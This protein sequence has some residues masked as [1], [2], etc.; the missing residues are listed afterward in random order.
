MKRTVL[1]FLLLV[2][3][4]IVCAA[5]TPTYDELKQQLNDKSLPLVNI[6]VDINRVSKPEY[7]NATIEIADPLARTDGNTV[8]TFNCKVKY[9]GATSLR[10]DKKSFAIKLLDADGKSLDADILGIREDD[11]WILGAMAIDRVRMRDRLC[12]DIW[13]EM[14][15]TPYDTKYNGRNGTK[16]YFVELFINGKYHGLYCMTDKVNR[17]LLNIKKAKTDKNNNTTINGVMYKCSEWC[18]AAFLSGYSTQSMNG[19]SWN[20]WELD[21]PDDYPCETA[22]T[23]LKE[24]IDYCTSTSDKDFTDGLDNHFYM[25][26]VIDYHTL[27]LAVGLRDNMMK[28]SFLSINDINSETRMMITPWDLDTSYGGEWEGS[29]YNHVAT[30]DS[31]LKVRPYAR[32]WKGNINRY[33]TAV[34][35][36][37]RTLSK[38]LLSKEN[39]NA[40]VDAYVKQMKESGAWEREYNAW[41][42]NPVELKRNLD[43]EADYIKAWFST[44]FDNLQNK[45]FAD[46]PT[47]IVEKKSDY[48]A[49]SEKLNSKSLPLVNITVDKDNI[50]KDDYTNAT[51]EITDPQKRTNNQL[52]AAYNCKVKYRG[53]SSLAYDKKSFTFKLLNEKGKSLDASLMGIREDDTWILDAMQTDPARMRDRLCFDLWNAFSFTPYDTDNSSRNGTKGYMVEVFINGDYHGLYCLTDKVNRKLLALTKAKKDDSGNPIIKGVLYK[54]DERSDAAL[55]KGYEEADTNGETWNG[56]TLEYPDDYP[57]EASYAPLRDFISFCTNSSNDDFEANIANNIQMQNFI[58]YHVF[59]LSQGLNDNAMN[60]TFL[61]IT[62]I[63]AGKQM[64]IT[65]WSL[66]NSLGWNADNKYDAAVADNATILAVKPYERLWQNKTDDYQ[67]RVAQRWQQLHA[68][69]L[70]EMMFNARVDAYVNSLTESGAWERERKAWG[71]NPVPLKENLS[72]E[73]AYMKEWYAKNSTHLTEEVFKDITSGISDIDAESGNARPTTLY[74]IQGQKVKPSYRGIII[75]NG[76][77][78]I[79]R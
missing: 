64:L 68:T 78:T 57:C 32:L 47:D 28:N 40:R 13:N 63:N 37:W 16:G 66:D 35:D 59:V 53:S 1:A 61:S 43:E 45:I 62:D 11:S 75:T 51:I 25:Q 71:G 48:V 42:R 20:S 6:T 30:N 31:A 41:N 54:C 9:R 26:N 19:A 5:S 36:R 79:Q 14:S 76:K 3:T 7:T 58:D 17:K 72:E 60:N 49:L 56:W 8:A 52:T 69:T 21:Y 27:Y 70:S 2:Q 39:F 15:Q 18:A 55:L 10:Y 74:N 12:F 38:T 4:M 73:A 46:I 34:A 77:K 50:S 22:Y 24:L 29:Y 67:W 23:P 44:N 33:Q 65:P